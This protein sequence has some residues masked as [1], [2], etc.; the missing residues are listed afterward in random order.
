MKSNRK[1]VTAVLGLVKAG[2]IRE[3]KPELAARLRVEAG[4]PTYGRAWRLFAIGV[5]NGGH[6]SADI[7][8]GYSGYIGWTARE[9]EQTLRT[10]YAARES[11]LRDVPSKVRAVCGYPSPNC[12]Q[13]AGRCFW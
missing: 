2:L 1:S 10:I 9:A 8:E 12:A 3:G 4:S 13:H 6:Y 11:A 5:E 7:G